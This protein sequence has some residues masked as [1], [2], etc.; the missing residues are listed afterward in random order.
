MIV[1]S[2]DSVSVS[3][4]DPDCGSGSGSGSGSGLLEGVDLK[5]I[6]LF[7]TDI[8]AV[9]MLFLYSLNLPCEKYSSIH[10]IN[11]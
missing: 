10:C 9:L 5:C 3:V 7:S 4:S 8:A 2:V 11:L 6:L 1:S